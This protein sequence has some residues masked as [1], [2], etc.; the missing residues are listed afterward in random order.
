[1]KNGKTLVLF[2]LLALSTNQMTANA[3]KLLVHG[4]AVIGVEPD[5]AVINIGV[6]NWSNEPEQS[7]KNNTQAMKNLVAALKDLGIARL[8]MQTW[9]YRF[10]REAETQNYRAEKEPQLG[11]RISNNL[12]VTIRDFKKLPTIIAAAVKTGGNDVSDLNFLVSKP[13][14]LINKARELAFA[15]ARKE[16]ELSA[17]AAGLK[18]GAML[19]ISNGR[20]TLPQVGFNGGSADMAA[21][22]LPDPD[23]LPVTLQGQVDVGFEI[24]VEYEAH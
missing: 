23:L 10:S 11:F 24:D 12:S 6:S 17:K 8:D 7:L 5:E 1:M 20:A 19:S 9:Q 3:A 16:A 14:A 21:T 2:A 13:E 18:L 15:D 4:R 22:N